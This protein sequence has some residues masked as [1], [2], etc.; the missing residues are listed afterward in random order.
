MI[1][2]RSGKS[3]RAP[4]WVSGHLHWPPNRF[5]A[6]LRRS[7]RNVREWLEQGKVDVLFEATSLVAPTGQPAIDHLTAA[8]ES[9]AH[10]ITA[11]KGPIVNAYKELT[12]LA[13]EKQRQFL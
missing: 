8:L 6:R 5:G 2:V 7:S 4:R 12:E 3:R 11:N 9:G 10:A 1:A 13:K